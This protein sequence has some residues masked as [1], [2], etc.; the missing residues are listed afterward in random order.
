M[1]FNPTILLAIGDLN[2]LVYLD[3]GCG[4]SLI[5]KTWLARKYPSQKVGIMSGPLKVWGINASRHKSDGFV[6]TTPYI[7]GLD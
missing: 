6:F 7:L 4:V 2:I 5:D 1:T 3:I